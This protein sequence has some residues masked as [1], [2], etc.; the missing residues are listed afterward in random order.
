MSNIFEADDSSTPLSEEEK[1][2]LKQK[3]I[4]TREELN[5][6][7]AKGIFE[8]QVWLLTHKANILNT[9]FLQK[10][11][12]KMFANV[13]K[14][15]G[16]FRVTEKNI[17]IAPYLISS[18]LKNLY[19]DVAYWIENK[20]Y[21]PYE[22]ALRFHHKLVHIH[23]FP[24]G[25]GRISRI[26]ADLIM[27]RLNEKEFDWGEGSLIEISKLRKNYINALR[28]AASGDYSELLEFIN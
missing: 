13:W 22:I 19:D 16:K 5:E 2:D 20:T 9:R 18:E 28:K 7:E 27:K 1:P 15:A 10:L 11:H 25:N 17:G 21:K 24:N 3:W 12:K 6:F 23:P 26:M 8:A 14:W 4:T